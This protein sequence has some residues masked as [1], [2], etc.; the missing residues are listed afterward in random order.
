MCALQKLLEVNPDG[1]L[2]P[3]QAFAKDVHIKDDKR[4]T[5]YTAL[6]NF[7][8]V[9]HKAFKLPQLLTYETDTGQTIFGPGRVP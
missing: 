8:D 2:M 6:N 3:A 4:T 1:L 7:I 5:I 9:G